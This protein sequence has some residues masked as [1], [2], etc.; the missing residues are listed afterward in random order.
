MINT[1]AQA[2]AEKVIA[3]WP[4]FSVWP[5][6][7]LNPLPFLV[8]QA[9]LEGFKL[10]MQAQWQSDKRQISEILKVGEK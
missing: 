9:V 8:A 5:H 7:A 10:G 4:E 1:E 3:A 2:I 6:L